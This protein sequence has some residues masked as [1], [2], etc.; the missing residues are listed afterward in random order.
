M[1]T[2]ALTAALIVTAPAAF[3]CETVTLGDL[4]IEHA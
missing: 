1:K 4:A 2:L 3:A